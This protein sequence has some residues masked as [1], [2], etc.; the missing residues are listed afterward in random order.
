MDVLRVIVADDHRLM[1]EALRMAL[2]DAPGIE[3]VGETNE[4]RK[5]LPLVARTKPDVALLDYRMPD[6]DGLACLDR[7]RQQYPSVVV[8]ILSAEDDPALVQEALRRGARAYILKQIDPR[9]LPSAIRQAV[10]STVYH[11]IGAEE[12][13]EE[14][15]DALGISPKERD[16]LTLVAR[17]LSNKEIARELWVSEQT[18]KFHLTNLYRKLN[19]ANRTEAA[20][21][22]FRLGIARPYEQASP[23]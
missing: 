19:V 12:Q 10:E 15:S 20:R 17:G 11:V 18:V 21:A 9:E 2:E 3:L 14:E 16:V 5:V 8:V 4:G 6:M 22:A 7:L 23:H 13:A 1:L